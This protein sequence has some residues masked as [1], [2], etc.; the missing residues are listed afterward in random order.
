MSNTIYTHLIRARLIGSIH[1]SQTVNVMHFG[2][3]TNS[4][5]IP[6]WNSR[7]QA[8]CQAIVQCAVTHL[9]PVVSSDWTFQRVEAQLFHPIELDP[10]QA[11]VPL[12]N[13]G[14]GGPQ[15]VTI[16]ASLIQLRTGR[17]GRRGRGRL[18]LPPA[19]EANI[20]G[21]N[22]D[23][24]W[25][26]ALTAFCLCLANNFGEP[27]GSSDFKLG[28][29]SRKDAAALGGSVSGAFRDLVQ[30]SP[31]ALAASMRTRKVGRGS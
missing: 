16:A 11:Q 10:V 13:V 1:N 6:D 4:V 19:G 17:D 22:W 3:N 25:L 29:F 23:A 20:A 31:Q 30:L 21:G 26:A 7:I 18:F 28:V 27:G 24:A 8:L 15:G 12:P 5:D 9:L 2:T 14:Q